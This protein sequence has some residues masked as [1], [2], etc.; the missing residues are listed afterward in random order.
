MLMLLVVVHAEK[1][2]ELMNMSKSQQPINK[3]KLLFNN[4]AYDYL[5]LILNLQCSFDITTFV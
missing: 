5:I 4:I 1:Y 3:V 2:Q